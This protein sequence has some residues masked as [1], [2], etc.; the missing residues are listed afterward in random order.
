M[1]RY[2]KQYLWL[3]KEINSYISIPINEHDILYEKY[4][5]IIKYKNNNYYY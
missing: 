3:L 2:R 1:I 4:I 5:I